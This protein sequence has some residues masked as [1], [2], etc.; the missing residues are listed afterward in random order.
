M[1]Y[2]T[3]Y[4]GRGKWFERN[5]GVVGGGWS[6]KRRQNFIV[7]RVPSL[8]VGVKKLNWRVALLCA[9]AVVVVHNPSKSVFVLGCGPRELLAFR[10]Q[11]P[12]D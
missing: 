11:A 1:Y 4:A 10:M 6:I 3:K 5:Q 7:S 12:A 8:V 2:T 9:A